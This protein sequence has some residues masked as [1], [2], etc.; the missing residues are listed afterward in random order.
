MNLN[1]NLFLRNNLRKLIGGTI[2]DNKYQKKGGQATFYQKAA[3]K[4]TGNFLPKS[5]LSPLNYRNFETIL[6]VY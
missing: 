1:G 6:E 4:G 3:K 5:S 2:C